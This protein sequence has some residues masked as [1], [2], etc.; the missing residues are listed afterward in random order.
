LERLYENLGAVKLE[1][2]PEELSDVN[3][4]ISKI[5]IAGDRYPEA[6]RKKT[7]R[8]GWIKLA[9]LF[10]RDEVLKPE[11]VPLSI[12]PPSGVM[13]GFAADKIFNKGLTWS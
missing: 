1:L 8:F 2:T 4:A 3:S 6:L 9:Q 10:D 11:W 7:L 5:T 12:T 13:A